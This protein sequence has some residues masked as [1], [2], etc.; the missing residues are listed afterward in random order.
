METKKTCVSNEDEI[1][2]AQIISDTILGSIVGFNARLTSEVCGPYIRH[3]SR[4]NCLHHNLEG[5]CDHLKK[6]IIFT[7]TFCSFCISTLILKLEMT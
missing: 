2:V 5:L 3:L 7:M 4:F 1:G 6:N